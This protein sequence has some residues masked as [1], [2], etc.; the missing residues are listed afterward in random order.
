MSVD[1]NGI[2]GQQPLGE[3]L[4]LNAISY[5]FF[6][7]RG[8]AVGIYATNN[9]EACEYV[10]KDS[11]ANIIVVENHEQLKKILKIWDNLPDLKAVVQ[12]T[13]EVSERHDNIYSVSTYTIILK[14]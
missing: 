3:I 7:F 5:Y 8:F 10:A 12:Y 4:R 2:P 1:V 14:S 9:A 13:G 11:K 6:I